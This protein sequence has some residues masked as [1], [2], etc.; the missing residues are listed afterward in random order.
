MA[1]LKAK[2]DLDFWTRKYNYYISLYKSK[3]TDIERSNEAARLAKVGRKAGMRTNTEVVDA[4]ADVFRSK[5]AQIN[6]QIGAIEALVNIE[7]AT[8]EAYYSFI[9]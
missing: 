7:L 2:N 5:A 9:Q 6:A 1:D 3:T 4:Q 8:G